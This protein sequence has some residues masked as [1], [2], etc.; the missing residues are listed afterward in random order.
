MAG[1]LYRIDGSWPGTLAIS[2][3]PRGG[4]WLQGEIDAWKSAGIHSIVSLL[5]PEEEQDLDLSNEAN[6]VRRQGLAFS[7]LPIPDR[8]VPESEAKV[9]ELIEDVNR[10]LLAGRNVLI[11]CRQ[12]VGRSGL[13]AACLLVRN[14]MS[15]GAAVESI[16]STRGVAVPET[17]E[18]RAWIERYAPAFAK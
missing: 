2:A 12:G 1:Q 16:S 6:E 11:H 8:Q 10:R 9:R 15:P 14:G 13:L 7:S 17:P 3:R 5:T 18:Q 4:D